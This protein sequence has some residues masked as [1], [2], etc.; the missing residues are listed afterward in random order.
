MRPMNRQ[1]TYRQYRGI[2][3]T[4]FAVMLCISETLIVKAARFWFPDQLYTVSVVGAL[5]AV[6]LMRWGGFAAIHALL[7]G[8]VF[9][10][11][12]G[13]T[14]SQTLIYC[15]G[16][17]FAMLSLVPRRLLGAERKRKGQQGE[18]NKQSANTNASSVGCLCAFCLYSFH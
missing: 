3:L 6:V 5:T 12:S 17:L 9:S 18:K 15:V 14:A 1:L 10:L 2:D 4:L 7:G 13:G 11:V 16:N 8:L